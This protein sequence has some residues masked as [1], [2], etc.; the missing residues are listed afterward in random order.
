[1]VEELHVSLQLKLIKFSPTK[2]TVTTFGVEN[3][4]IAIVELWYL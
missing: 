2:S 3:I 4:H 1:M